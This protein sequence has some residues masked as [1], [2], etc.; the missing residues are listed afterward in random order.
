[1]EMAVELRLKHVKYEAESSKV[2]KLDCE[3]WVHEMLDCQALAP[4][5]CKNK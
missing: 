4:T 2:N 1:M 3:E 5:N